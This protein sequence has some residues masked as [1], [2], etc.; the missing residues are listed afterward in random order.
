VKNKK[1]IAVS[2]TIVLVCVFIFNACKPSKE[3]GT[4]PAYQGTNNFSY[5]TPAYDSAKKTVVVIANNYG[6]ELFDMLAPYY[7][8]NATGKANVYIIA[9]D[10]FPIVVRKGFYILPQF[11]FSDFDAHHLKPNVIVIPFLYAADSLHQD[12]VIVDWIKKYYTLETTILAVCD[13]AA[14]AA[15]T[16]IFD[17]KPY[18]STCF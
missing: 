10:K 2:I 8:F 6:T 7:L 11:T 13:G 16:G 1:L 9:K 18:Y 17:G 3:F 12:S 15:A 5:Q 14:T 4:M